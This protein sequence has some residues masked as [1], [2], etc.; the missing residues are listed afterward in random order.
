MHTVKISNGSDAATL[1]RYQIVQ[2]SNDAHGTSAVNNLP[3]PSRVGFG[4]SL[5]SSD[6]SEPTVIY[7]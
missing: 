4:R 7:V 3:L 6:Y 1:C 5:K 2:S